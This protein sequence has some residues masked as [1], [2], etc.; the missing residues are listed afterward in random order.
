MND[1]YNPTPS[2][3]EFVGRTVLD[4]IGLVIPSIDVSLRAEMDLPDGVSA[5]G[6]ISS[7]TGA[8][9]QICAVDEAVKNTNT[10]LDF[11]AFLWYNKLTIICMKTV[12]IYIVFESSIF[13]KQ[14]PYS[15]TTSTRCLTWNKLPRILSLSGKI[16]V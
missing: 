16:L 8:A 2:L 5:L 6:V 13:I 9:G 1:I 3:P 14:S 4:T 11:F 7:R 12:P 10:R 15:S